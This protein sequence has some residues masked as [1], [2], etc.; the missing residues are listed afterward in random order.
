ML[1]VRQTVF[2]SLLGARPTF[3]GKLSPT[4]IPQCR[5]APA[6]LFPTVNCCKYGTRR[7]KVIHQNDVARFYS[8]TQCNVCVGVLARCGVITTMCSVDIC[9]ITCFVHQYVAADVNHAEFNPL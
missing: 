8:A 9:Q 1:L 3:G 4:P 5:T 7:A 2:L 6:F